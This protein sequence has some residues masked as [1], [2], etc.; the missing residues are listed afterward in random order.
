MPE[1]SEHEDCLLRYES[2][3]AAFDADPVCYLVA[4]DAWEIALLQSVLRY[5][6]W[7]A[8]WR[9]L[10]LATFK[11]VDERVNRL[12]ECLMS[13]CDVSA[14]IDVIEAGFA[15]LHEDLT[16]EDSGLPLIEDIGDNVGE[17]EDDLA[18]VWF[19]VKAVASILGAT[20][21]APPTPL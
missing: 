9:D 14:L 8:R 18:N 3:A 2:M 16:G 19:T 21:G 1:A 12:E 11:E 10:G 15:Q 7:S 5:A 6:H 13:G 17:L 20:V 4:L